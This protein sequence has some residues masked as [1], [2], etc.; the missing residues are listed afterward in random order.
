[1]KKDDDLDLDFQDIKPAFLPDPDDI[2][3]TTVTLENPHLVSEN[4]NV[5]VSIDY[6]LDYATLRSISGYAASGGYY[7][8]GKTNEE[9]LL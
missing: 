9:L 4:S 6:K 5:S 8:N 2:W 7:V 3:L 1:M